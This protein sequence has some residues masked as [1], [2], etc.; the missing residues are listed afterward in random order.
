MD[1]IAKTQ[2]RKQ[3]AIAWLDTVG[4][5]VAATMKTAPQNTIVPPAPS[6]AGTRAMAVLE[7]LSG[8]S[9]GASIQLV[10]GQVI[11]EGG[12][13]IVREAEQVSLGRTVAVKML[14]RRD[15]SAA[16]DLLRE[17]WVTGAIEH[18]NVVPVH[19]VELDSEGMPLV[20]LK[21]VEGASWHALAQ[22]AAEV[23]R[24][25]GATDLLAWN[26]GVLMQ[27]LNAVRYAHHR[28]VVHR[29][30]KPSNVMIGDFGE[31]YLLDWGIAVSLRDDGSGRLPLAASQHELAGTPSY[32]APEMLGRDGSPALSERTDVYLAG[33][34][35]YE[36][37]TGRVPHQGDDII[38]VI[39][40]IVTSEPEMPASAP[41]ELA[42]ICQ[43]AMHESPD[44]RYP[45]AEALR[46]A[47]QAYLEHR[48]ST[49][50]AR[51][52]DAR[53]AEL[54][55]LLATPG[56]PDRDD[57]YRVFGAARFGFHEALAVWR[58]NAEARAGLARATVAVAEFELAAGRPTAAV[59]LLADVEAP[60]LLARAKAAAD[61]SARELLALER[62]R[63]QQDSTIGRRT[64]S[65][66]ALGLGLVFSILPAGEYVFH[67][68]VTPLRAVA[69][70]L[71]FLAGAALLGV[72]ARHTMM[73]TQF[74][75]RLF[76]TLL[77]LFIA[78]A[79]VA[80]G[81]ELYGFDGAAVEI[82][83]MGLW[84]TLV[85]MLAIMV[86]PWLAP[87][88]ASYI[89]GFLLAAKYPAQHSLFMSATNIVF[90]VNA[91]WRW[92]PATLLP[93]P[94]ERAHPSWPGRRKLR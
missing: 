83:H 74:N 58:D 69:L 67:W 11:G 41:P 18:P 30:L 61:R 32:M 47:L 8:R 89:V 26:L 24:R 68:H 84:V 55:E 51:R 48:G 14:K 19:F 53:L 2:K 63:D 88:C 87:S 23:A 22:D 34:V 73:A 3:D 44:E 17:A 65:A 4:E 46:L 1:S 66:L 82:V 10:H 38:S 27:V 62:L 77:F 25:F 12:M 28:G 50:L 94:A 21:R 5:D 90:S 71:V 33:A 29:D 81:G 86:D 15:P 85:G 35:L 13:G 7:Q 20:V 79:V 39:A 42:R 54:M 91:I 57:L 70:S 93:T 31:V 16:L 72:W 9:P 49:E 6:T 59:S 43:R 76:A 80:L 78:Q 92:R 60:A 56:G 40:S 36:L 75:R 37:V 64:R 45:S 52:A